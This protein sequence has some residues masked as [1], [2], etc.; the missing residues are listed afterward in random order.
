MM[1]KGYTIQEISLLREI[2]RSTI[3]GWLEKEKQGLPQVQKRGRRNKE[4]NP[5]FVDLVINHW[6]SYPCGSFKM[7]YILKKRGFGV[8]QRQIQK[9]YN[10]SNFKMNKRRRPNQIKFVKYEWPE[11]N[12]LWHVDWTTCPYTGKQLIAFI[13]DYSRFIVHAEFFSN[14]T[15]E[16][17]ILAFENAMQKHGKPENIL[18]DNGSQFTNTHKR[19]DPKH[20][21]TKFCNKNGIKHILGR[22]HHPQTNGKIERWFGTYKG[23]MTDHYKNLDH[24]VYIYNHVRPHQS[25]DYDVPAKRFFANT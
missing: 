2:P 9:I 24:F 19:G 23:E 8:S 15:I 7:Y 12:A 13:D 4:I 25:L 10:T 6:N 17:T 11:P 5:I 16:N 3:Y 1:R 20:E 14:A 22:I 21:F 18:S